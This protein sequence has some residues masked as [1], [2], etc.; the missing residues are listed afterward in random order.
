MHFL[1]HFYLSIFFPVLKQ[2]QNKT[3]PG[4][5]T[6]LIWGDEWILPLDQDH[7]G[8][9]DPCMLF[10]WSA[11]LTGMF[12]YCWIAIIHLF[13]VY[14][15]KS[16]WGVPQGSSLFLCCSSAFPGLQLL[17]RGVY[18]LAIVFTTG[19]CCCCCYFL[20]LFSFAAMVL[21]IPRSFWI[22]SNNRYKQCKGANTCFGSL[23]EVLVHGHVASCSCTDNGGRGVCGRKDYLS[24]GGQE[25]WEQGQRQS[26]QVTFIFILFRLTS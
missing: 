16:I 12:V 14:D 15:A 2:K 18:G 8:Q 17:S 19:C 4:L 23:S 22:H 9:T 10:L 3:K 7:G 21:S 1:L 24:R 20:L 25:K 13:Q 11:W 6:L 26:Q 5:L